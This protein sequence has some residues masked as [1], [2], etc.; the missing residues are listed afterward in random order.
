MNRRWIGVRQEIL[1]DAPLVGAESQCGTV[2]RV[3]KIDRYIH[4]FGL[5]YG[6]KELH[7]DPVRSADTHIRA[8]RSLKGFGGQFVGRGQ[9]AILENGYSSIA[10]SSDNCG[11]CNVASNAILPVCLLLIS[12][13][14]LKYGLWNIYDGP[15]TLLG[16]LSL[17]AGWFP[18]VFSV[19]LLIYRV[20]DP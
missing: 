13:I 3:V 4:I 20:F 18:L 8:L 16:P 6:F 12:A 2:T 7:N 17:V 1:W 5:V 10:P 15:Q 9:R 14:F 19:W 11:Q